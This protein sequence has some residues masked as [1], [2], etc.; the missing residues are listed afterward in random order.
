MR[1]SRVKGVKDPA[2]YIRANTT[3]IIFSIHA[4][5]IAARARYLQQ[6]RRRRERAVASPTQPGEGKKFQVVPNIYHRVFK[7]GVKKRG[8]SVKEAK[9]YKICCSL[10]L[11]YF[12]KW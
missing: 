12:S 11:C 1:S 7:F 2:D 10:L 9:T 6:T 5:K 8:K 3:N 4:V